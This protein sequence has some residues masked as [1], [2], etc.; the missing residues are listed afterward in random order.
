MSEFNYNETTINQNKNMGSSKQ[1]QQVNWKYK[2][3]VFFNVK[4][5]L[6]Y[7]LERFCFR[8]HTIFILAVCLL[9]IKVSVQ[10]FLVKDNLSD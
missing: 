7:R 3:N 5:C 6:L 2:V 10:E 1:R 8:S 4:S 9:C